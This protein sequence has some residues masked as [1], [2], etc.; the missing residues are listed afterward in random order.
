MVFLP[1]AVQK[2]S[3]ATCVPLIPI[4]YCAPQ[5][6][7]QLVTRVLDYLSSKVTET[8][9][10]KSIAALFPE[11][12]FPIVSAGIPIQSYRSDMVRHQANSIALSE[13]VDCDHNVLR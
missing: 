3:T 12:I 2:L 11:I 6:D 5:D 8:G 9:H 4:S 1:C 7:K 13:L 10:F